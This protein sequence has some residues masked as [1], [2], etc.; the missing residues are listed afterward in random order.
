M[1]MVDFETAKKFA[2]IDHTRQDVALTIVLDAIE[3]WIQKFAGLRFYDT[4]SYETIHED[5]DGGRQ[6]LWLRVHPIVS[7]IGIYDRDAD[8]DQT[9]STLY[10]FNETRIWLRSEGRWGDG[11]ERWHVHYT[12]GYIPQNIPPMLNLLIMQLFKRAYDRAGGKESESVAGFSEK[13]QELLTSDELVQLRA[14]SFR[15]TLS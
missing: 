6:S 10:R 7:V 11:T 9:D 8:L 4:G 15:R 13:W 1:S 3:D 2:M 5:V 12:A 14:L